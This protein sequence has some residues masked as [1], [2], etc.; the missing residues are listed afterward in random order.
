[1]NDEQLDQR[2]H[3]WKVNDPISDSFRQDV[4]QR[5]HD[6]ESRR[7]FNGWRERVQAFLL[8]MQQPAYA[9]AAFTFLVLAG[10]SAG[11]ILG[12]ASDAQRR[13]NLKSQYVT[14]INPLNPDRM[15]GMQ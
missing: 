6:A 1:M 4:W 12:S 2:L 9:A 15:A 8:S 14:A 7:T 3:E 5:I 11:I 13:D 10:F